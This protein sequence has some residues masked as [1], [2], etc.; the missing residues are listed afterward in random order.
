MPDPDIFDN[1]AQHRFELQ[2]DGHTAFLLYSK[3]GGSLRLIH[4]EVPEALR[5]K[6][7]ASKLVKGVLRLAQQNR[8]SIIPSCPFVAQYIKRHPD[9]FSLVD[10][11]YIWMVE[12]G[13]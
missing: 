8:L 4:T 5:G 2:D 10:R 12:A 6:G 1:T 9:Y 3:T 7:I 11:Q 13:S